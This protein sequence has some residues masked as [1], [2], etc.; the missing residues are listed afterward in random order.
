MF[1]IQGLHASVAPKRQDGQTAVLEEFTFVPYIDEPSTTT[2]PDKDIEFHDVLGNGPMLKVMLD[3]V[4]ENTKTTNLSICELGAVEN[5]VY[6][7]VVPLINLHPLMHLNY[8]ATDKTQD[9]LSKIEESATEKGVEVCVWNTANKPPG[10][11]GKV[12]LVISSN[13]SQNAESMAQV[14]DNTKSMLSPQGFLLVH[15]SSP[16]ARNKLQSLMEEAGFGIAAMKQTFGDSSLTLYRLLRETI[17]KEPVVIDIDDSFAWVPDLHSKFN[18]G[19]GSTIWLRV[20]SPSHS[21]IVGMTNCLRQEP[22]GERIRCLFDGSNSGEDLMKSFEE[23]RKLDLVMNVYNQGRLGS[24]RHLPM[25]GEGATSEETEHA[26]V[27]VLTR[28][29]LSSLRWIA[30]HLK[31]APGKKGDTELCSVNY[32]SLNFRDIMLATGKLPPDALPGDLAQ[33]DCILGM[34]FSGRNHS[35]KRIMGLLPAQ[36]LATTVLADQRFTWEVPEKWSLLDAAT[37]PVVYST[38]YYALIVRGN[39]RPGQSVL[40]HSGSGGVGQAAISICLSMGCQVYTTLGSK[41][42]R[43]YLLATFPNLKD[44]NIG[45]SRDLSFEPMVSVAFENSSNQLPIPVGY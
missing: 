42:K 41:E 27:N 5:Q 24:Y 26:Y 32:A 3:I 22:C 10:S 25:G 38:A 21:G 9:L 45:N 43:E 7:H 6:S 17:D 23:L 2:P 36:A 34:E 12:D 39:L 29:D 33:Q 40:I 11:M 28:G 15:E 1:F 31:Y 44:E 8:T 4:I 13:F 20:R 16:E 18:T 35:G 30:S 19:D 37:V 14:V